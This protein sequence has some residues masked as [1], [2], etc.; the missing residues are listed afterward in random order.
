MHCA[1]TS[2]TGV[3]RHLYISV[4]MIIFIIHTHTHTQYMRKRTN[5]DW[6]G[7]YWM[8]DISTATESPNSEPIAVL[9]E[10]T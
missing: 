4:H 6:I 5:W 9:S 10:N 2:I 1:F 3:L 8:N 7:V